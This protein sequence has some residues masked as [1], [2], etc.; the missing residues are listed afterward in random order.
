MFSFDWLIPLPRWQKRVISVATDFVSLIL[1]SLIAVWLRLG[2][3]DLPHQFALAIVVLPF[4]AL[5]VFIRLGLYR[6]VVRYI[7]HRFVFTVFTAVSL[8]FLIW[9]TA[10]LMLDLAY[11]RSA[12]IIAWLMAIL[13]ITGS[14][15][16][17]R[18]FL[19][20]LNGESE[21]SESIVIFG[22]GDA[23][24][25]L[26]QALSGIAHKKVV[27]FIDDDKSLYQQK[28]G[29]IKVYQRTDLQE[30]INRFQVKEILLATPG[31]NSK[32]RKVVLNWLAPFPIKVST[33]PSM[34]EIVDGT[35][36]FSDVREVSIE[37][38]LGRDAVPA[39][40][41]L[42]SQCITDKV[43]MVTGG[44]GSI[45]SELCRQIIR[46]K[47]QKLIIFEL[48]E[49][50]LYSI[51]QELNQ[52]NA[53]ANQRIELITILGDIK[54]KAKLESLVKQYQVE[55]IYHA[56]AYKH[57]PLVE[58]N[59]AEGIYNN[60]FGTL[61][62]AEV[63]AE[64]SVKNFVLVST[65][66]AVRPTNFMGA[67]KRLA[68]LSLQALQDEYPHTRFVMVRFGNVLGS[69]GSVIPLFKQQI[70]NGGPVTV[71]HK[72]ITRYFM[73]I[74]EA[75][76]L[77]IQAGSMGVGGDVFV[78]DMGEPVKIADLAEKLI[79]LSGLEIIDSE[80][81]GDI[82]IQYTGLRPGEKLF[83]ELLIGE[84]VDGTDHPRIMK[85]H[86][87]YIDYQALKLELDLIS[88]LL[89]NHEYSSVSKK[90]EQLVSGF[91]HTSGIVDYIQ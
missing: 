52:L 45:G 8:S 53:I 26:M 14:R 56:A 38:L 20:R 12:L 37:D 41:N 54:N 76:S 2:T 17:I 57:V 59:I 5:P 33:L 83:E 79:K 89:V 91:K 81:H 74:P 50:A 24:R 66:K 78:L 70:A 51:Q 18:W 88:K 85:A 80:G 61:T 58:H 6:A 84:N 1:I 60:S 55:T 71:T 49:F 64:N 11:P 31:M 34:E 39:Q 90:L 47:P 63:A 67:S 4:L 44:G 23:G 10:I 72:E 42:L 40:D 19:L 46:H 48:S 86:E 22:A 16:I 36:S 25:Q 27:A 43:V 75:A 65:D 87:D 21:Q 15:L 13:Y 68:E 7:T 3:I 73:T 28:I 9:S 82:E 30:L 77:V 62:V 35:V 69:S 32:Q 29:A